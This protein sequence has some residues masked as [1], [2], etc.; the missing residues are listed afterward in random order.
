M[1]AELA[2]LGLL[3]LP[4]TTAAGE[5]RFEATATVRFVEDLG[6]GA[7]LS[8]LVVGKRP[9]DILDVQATGNPCRDLKDAVG[10]SVTVSGRCRPVFTVYGSLCRPNIE[11]VGKARK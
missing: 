5:T 1:R 8:R 10:Q 3:A 2:L 11:K 7:C 4:V 9:E 6:N